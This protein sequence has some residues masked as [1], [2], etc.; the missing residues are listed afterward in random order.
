MLSSTLDSCDRQWFT[1]FESALD[2]MVVVNAVGNMV[3]INPAG[4]ELL[5]GSPQALLGRRLSDFVENGEFAHPLQAAGQDGQPRGELCLMRADGSVR[6]VEYAVT[7]DFLPDGHLWILRDVTE[8]KH[9]EQRVEQLQRQLS[10]RLEHRTA[11]WQAELAQRQKTEAALR[12]S[13]QKYQTLFEI[14]PIGVSITDAA[15][16]LIETNAASEQ[17]LGVPV[18]DHTQRT[19]DEPS[20]GMIRPDGSPMPPEEYPVVRALREQ[21]PILGV[22]QGIV[23]SDG[24]VHWILTSAAPI[25]LEPY[26]AAIAYIDITQQKQ[27]D[28]AL[29][30]SEEQ[31]KLALDL[32]KTGSWEFNVATGE[33]IWNENQFH[34]M[35]LSPLESISHYH[36]WRDRVHP[37]DLAFAEAAFSHALATH[38][39]L[40]VEYRV[41]HPDGTVRW[42][43]TRG[44]GIY[45]DTG[46]AQKM[47]GVMLDISDRKAAELTLRES[48]SRFAA[49]FQ[50]SPDAIVI[51]RLQA[52]L[53]LEV[54]TQ[55]SQISGYTRAE[56]IGKTTQ[57]LQVWTDPA[58][59]NTLLTRL[60]QQATI[61]SH[62]ASFRRKSG[63]TFVGLFSCQVIDLGGQTC[64]LSV[65]RDI[66]DRKA[67]ELALQESESKFQEIAAVSPA[68]IFTLFGDSIGHLQYEYISPVAEEIHEIPLVEI[69]RDGRLLAKQVHPDDRAEYEQ[70][71]AYCLETRQPFQ[72]EWRIITPSGKIK[73]LSANARPQERSTDEIV[74]HGI[75]IDVS[76]R[77]QSELA[78]QQSEAKFQELAAVSPAIIFTLA[79]GSEGQVQFEYLSPA[80][81]EIHEIPVAELLQNR[82]LIWEQFHPDDE[83]GYEQAV[84]QSLAT[85]QLFQ[86]EWRIIT[87]SGKTKWLSANARPQQRETGEIL[88]HGIVMDISDRKQSELALE[89]EIQRRQI[90]VESSFDGIVVI[91]SQGNVVEA[92]TSFANMLGYS[93]EEVAT[94]NVVDWEAQLTPEEIAACQHSTMPCMTFETRNRRRDGTVINVEISCNRVDWE[95]EVLRFCIC[96]DISDRK[97]A[98]QE[99]ATT[100][101]FLQQVLDYLPMAVF[102]KDAQTLQFTLWNNACIELMGYQPDQVLGK[103]D[104]ELFPAAQADICV[105]NDRAAIQSRRVVEVPEEPIVAADGSPRIVHNR[106]VAVYGADGQ[107]QLVIGMV[108]DITQRKAAEAALHQREEEF[109]ALVENSPDGIIR[110]D[111]QFRFLYVNPAIITLSGLPNT[112][113]LGKTSQEIGFPDFLVTLWHG[114][115]ERV[116]TT[117]QEQTLEYA[118]ALENGERIFYSRIVPESQAD[119]TVNSVLVVARDITALKRAQD[120]LLY[121]AERER[122]LRLIAQHIRATLDLDVILSTA[123]HEVQYTLNADRTLIFRLNSDHSGVVIQEAVRPEYPVTLEMRWEDECFP[124]ACYA[125]YSLGQGRIVSDVA[126]DTWGECLVDFMQQTQVR[127]KMVAPITQA[128]P[129]GSLLVWGLLITHACAEPR[130]WQAEELELLQQVAEQLAIAIYQAEL[131]DQVRQLNRTLEHQVQE[132]TAKLQ[133]A[134]DFE[135]LLRQ[136]TDQVRDS[137]DEDQIL[138]TIV[139]GLG[140]GLG[141]E[142]CDTGIY[143]A[144]QTTSTIAHEFTRLLAP[145]KGTTFAIADANHA[146]L[147]PFLFRGQLLQFCDLAP[148]TLRPNQGQLTVLACPIRD[149]QRIL[150]DLWLSKLPENAFSDLEVRL[151]QQVAN[152][153]AIALRQS[154][155]YQ[156]AQSQVTELERLNH[157]K[158]DFLSTVSHE[159]RTPM[160]NIKMAT[161]LVELQLKQHNLL[162][163]DFP[164]PNHEDVT[165]LMRYFQILKDEGRREISLINDLLDLARLDAQSEPLSLHTVELSSW[166]P[167]L[168]EPFVARAQRQ[169]QCFLLDLP[170]DLPELTTDLSYFQ[171][172]IHELLTNA[173]KYTPP[174]GTIGLSIWVVG[175]RLHCVICN[176]GVEI[177]PTECDRIFDRFYRIP[178]GDPWKHGG[179]GLGLAL[180]KK[181]AD[182]LN[183]NIRVESGEGKTRFVLEMPLQITDENNNDANN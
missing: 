75:A 160:S 88:W 76:D 92:N 145:A 152:H 38:T 29:R 157:L 122:T 117:G 67:A 23:R 79:M 61:H 114:A 121:Q 181:L 71:V 113:F 166:I 136:I 80:A 147:Y 32:S 106:K 107:P 109:R 19:C 16:N 27:M 151:V 169:N 163:A 116:F 162:P 64:L 28:A 141:L 111:R 87:P 155:L 62:E 22:E 171:R 2:G 132:R 137:L 3:A 175:D 158:D 25:P 54:N 14:L 96:Q 84:L 36:T 82:A 179:T 161:E 174:G 74:W 95:G 21:R 86:H 156:A 31:R 140:Q 123:V 42:M 68:V 182:H 126:M 134:L 55:F 159:L 133:Q 69:L 60:Q 85:M 81:A 93:L 164:T 94:L 144:D 9:L 83:A 26:G 131:H 101:N 20:W 90:L 40:E 135:A 177:S 46:T 118:I 98:E 50:S 48:E 149:D 108:E 73:W 104:Y 58:E 167:H 53:I 66:S 148:C 110:C 142:C 24:T 103:T 78:L 59:R 5:G 49:V 4:G 99:L 183:G 139:T 128:Q 154:R 18:E 150:G 89:R 57:Q 138:E 39:N 119:G 37:D 44:Q 146:E 178:N 112:A 165:P 11:D 10:Q 173:C 129:D 180:V 91:D 124:P 65:I 168:T 6:R 47:V 153:C 56:A 7:A 105:A 172:I 1:L 41:I 127:S 33:A 45:D 120:A 77:K 17:I 100:R 13:Q 15:G 8:R 143:S 72:H 51:T 125:A 70:I 115:M 63:E 12:A 176:T 52:G 102:A 34:L 97:Q 43:L 130:Q 30:R 170:A 35:G